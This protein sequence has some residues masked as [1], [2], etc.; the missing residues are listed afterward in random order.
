MPY[1]SRN[2]QGE[3][4][5]VR[6]APSEQSNEWLDVGDTEILEFLKRIQTTEQAKQALSETDSEMIRVIEDLVDLLISKNVFNFTDLPEV[7]Q[8][9]LG[10]RKQIR[11]EMNSLQNLVGDD[12][13]IF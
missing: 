12:D 5:G 10:A 6:D 11:Q 7:V 8:A 1:V 3:V 4:I 13:A 9:K 2:E